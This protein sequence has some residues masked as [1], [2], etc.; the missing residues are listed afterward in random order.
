MAAITSS[1]GLI[2]GINT[3]QI[4]DELMSLESQPVTLL[5]NQINQTNTQKSAYTALIQSLQTL[6]TTGQT[7]EK[8]ATFQAAT[9]NSSNQNVL[10]ATAANGAAIGSYSLQVA[11]LV[12]TQQAVSNGFA[13]PSSTPVGAGTITIDMGGGQ[14]TSATTLADLNGGSGVAAGSF[15]I[16]DSSGKSDVINTSAD[17]TVDDVLQQ[18]NNSLDVSVRATLDGD[19]IV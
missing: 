1:I 4:I 9:A 8:P 17:V 14:L 2:S 5:Q 3:G 18:I 19:K 13:D 15:R 16:T 12:S 7:L 10:T 11:Q 6:Q